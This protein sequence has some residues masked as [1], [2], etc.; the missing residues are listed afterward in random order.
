MFR[1]TKVVFGSSC[2]ASNSGQEDCTHKG[3]W[4][5]VKRFKVVT[6]YKSQEVW[7]PDERSGD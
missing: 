5:R 6:A 2:A 3:Q 7:V 1:D 4:G